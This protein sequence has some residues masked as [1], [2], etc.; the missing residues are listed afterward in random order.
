MLSIEISFLSNELEKS[1]FI[2]Q[3]HLKATIASFDSIDTFF[4]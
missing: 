2:L 4:K 1:R 3:A